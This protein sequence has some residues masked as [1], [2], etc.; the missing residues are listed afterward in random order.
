M[1]VS[2]CVYTTHEQV[3]LGARGVCYRTDRRCLSGFKVV[4]EFERREATGCE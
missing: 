3:H 2:L 4:W 1:C